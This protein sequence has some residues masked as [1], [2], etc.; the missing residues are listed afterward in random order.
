MNFNDFEL[1][2]MIFNKVLISS[3]LDESQSMYC[4]S[5]C[6]FLCNLKHT[7]PDKY[8]SWIKYIV[9][10][11]EQNSFSKD[12]CAGFI[13]DYIEDAYFP[14][15]EANLICISDDPL[16]INVYRRVLTVLHQKVIEPFRAKVVQIKATATV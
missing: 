1:K 16:R 11:L 4:L 14:N 8:D 15:G 5:F 6:Q 9:S 3:E 12:V 10:V 2:G 7:S 13:K